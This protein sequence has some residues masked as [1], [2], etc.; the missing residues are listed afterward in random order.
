MFTCL[1]STVRNR[2][3]KQNRLVRIDAEGSAADTQGNLE[4]VANAFNVLARFHCHLSVDRMS[5]A[6]TGSSRS[7][8]HS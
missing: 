6:S 5:I 1:D 4:P 8:I 7:D 2:L 3:I